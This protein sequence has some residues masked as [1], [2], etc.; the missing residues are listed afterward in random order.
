MSEQSVVQVET[1]SFVEGAGRQIAP[2]IKTSEL[3]SDRK[4]DIESAIAETVDTVNDAMLKAGEAGALRVSKV[5]ASFGIK[6]KAD[7]GVVLTRVGG[8]C[9]LEVKITIERK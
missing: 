8:E 5:E 6:L 1:V 3:L 9:S 4:A 7:A 2:K